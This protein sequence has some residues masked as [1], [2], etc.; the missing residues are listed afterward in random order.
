[1]ID[2]EFQSPPTTGGGCDVDLSV[3]D[4]A[5][6]AVSI[7]THHGGRVRRDDVRDDTVHLHVSIPTH[8]GGRVRL[9]VQALCLSCH[10]FNPHPPRGAG[11]THHPILGPVVTHRFNPHPPRG[12]GATAPKGAESGQFAM[13]TSQSRTVVTHRIA[14]NRRCGTVPV[15]EAHVC[16]T[17]ARGSRM[18]QH[19][20]VT[21]VEL[22]LAADDLQIAVA[23]L[24]QAVDAQAVLF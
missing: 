8:H 16:G 2:I 3:F 23:R 18:L 20:R 5:W 21:K 11:A 13:V 9:D 24:A 19:Q 7:P 6:V 15:R 22:G 12:A 4:P 14:P 1:M 10:S 17:I